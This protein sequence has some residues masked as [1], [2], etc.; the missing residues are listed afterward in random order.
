MISLAVYS[1]KVFLKLMNVY[2]IFK[3][4]TGYCTILQETQEEIDYMCKAMEDMHN[5]EKKLD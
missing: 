4:Y 5:E 1:K 2:I 3:V